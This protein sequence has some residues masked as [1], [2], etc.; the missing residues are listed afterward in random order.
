MEAD[1]QLRELSEELARAAQSHDEP[2]CIARTFATPKPGSVVFTMGHWITL[3]SLRSPLLQ[4]Q[5]PESV[6]EAE[7]SANVFGLSIQDLSAEEAVELG[8]RLRDAIQDGF[9]MALKMRPE[10]GEADT[11]ADGFGT[12]LPVFT[13]LITE[14]H[15]PPFEARSVPVGQALAILAARRRNQGWRCG[16]ATYAERDALKGGADV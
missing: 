3:E 5:I 9:A 11:A 14:C 2:R 1:A 4:A 8:V 13:F 16:G 15:C 10:E 12:W 7:T 6:E